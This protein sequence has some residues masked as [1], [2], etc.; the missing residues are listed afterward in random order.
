[1]SAKVDCMGTWIRVKLA[2]LDVSARERPRELRAP[3]V[4]GDDAPEDLV[5]NL[6]V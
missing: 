5:E 4:V 2:G 1:M 3:P 6:A